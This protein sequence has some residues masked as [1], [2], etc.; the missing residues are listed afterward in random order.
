MVLALSKTL[1]QDKPKNQ[2]MP[3]LQLQGLQVRLGPELRAMFPVV[4]NMGISGDIEINGPADPQTMTLH[5]DI[6]LESG[7]VAL[8]KVCRRS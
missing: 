7:E 2:D 8:P 6:K 5:G 1:L 3:A 4:V